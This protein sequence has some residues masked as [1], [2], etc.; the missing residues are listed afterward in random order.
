MGLYDRD[1][2]RDSH[3]GPFRD[4]RLRSRS[5]VAILIAIN[6]AV[7][8]L[9]LIFLKDPP[10]ARYLGCSPT[11]L[12]H[13]GHVWQ[14]V[15]ANFLHSVDQ[16]HI[17]HILLNMFYLYMFGRELE[18]I[19]GRW[20]FLTLYLG[21]GVIAVL[22]QATI[23]L[24]VRDNAIIIGASGAVMGVIFLYAFL[25]P[26]REVYLFALV[27]IQ[28]WMICL[29]FVVLDL[30]GIVS[31]SAGVAHWA[32]LAGGATGVLY[33]FVDLRWETIRGRWG[34][35]RRRVR[36]RGARARRPGEVI[37]FPVSES[38][39][40]R[41]RERDSVSA[42]IDELLD[43]IHREGK[44]SLSEEELEFLKSNSQFYRSE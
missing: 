10:L 37:Q 7:W 2:Y 38:H 20:N 18:Q 6:V 14:L 35:G 21:A 8:I 28:I 39:S 36:F 31:G 33:R 25:F 24:L 32:H 16:G 9:Q 41:T 44:D 15:T 29:L 26:R 1:Y 13:R 30:G 23:G 17:G 40:H 22:T 11:D 34:G 19:Y 42:R 4:W 5:V 12:F 27:P 43:K 3:S